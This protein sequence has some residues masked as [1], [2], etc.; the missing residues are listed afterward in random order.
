MDEDVQVVLGG[1]SLELIVGDD[2]GGHDEVT[3]TKG[4]VEE[5]GKVGCEASRAIWRQRF[6]PLYLADQFPRGRTRT[7][8]LTALRGKPPQIAPSRGSVASR[9]QIMHL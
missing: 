7:T 2:L 6:A 9:R 8:W 5:G 4:E 1:V 3:T